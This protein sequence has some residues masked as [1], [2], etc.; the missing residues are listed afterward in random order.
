MAQRVVAQRRDIARSIRDAQ[1]LAIAVIGGCLDGC[2]DIG[3]RIF[4]AAAVLPRPVPHTVIDAVSVRV[5]QP[6]AID[7]GL[8]GQTVQRGQL[9][10]WAGNTGPG[11]KRGAGGPN[12]HLHIFFCRRDPTN[13]EWYFFDPY[14]VYSLPGCYAANVTDATT[15]PCVRYPIAWKFGKPQYP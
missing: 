11:G 2:S 15:G 6:V 9:L 14:G 4:H 7:A 1:Y 10:A 12:T 5:P 8:L 13:D 3:V